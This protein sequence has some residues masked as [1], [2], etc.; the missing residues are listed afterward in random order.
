MQASLIERAQDPKFGKIDQNLGAQFQPK[1]SKKPSIE[2]AKGHFT[3]KLG[4]E[5]IFHPILYI[6]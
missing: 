6:I 2:G 4:F 5:T 3:S 1:I